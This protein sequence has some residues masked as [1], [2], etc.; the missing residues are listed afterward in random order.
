[1]CMSYRQFHHAFATVHA[2]QLKEACP[3]GPLSP[4]SKDEAKQVSSNI[5]WIKM[6]NVF[7]TS[8]LIHLAFLQDAG[9]YVFTEKK[10]DKIKRLM[11]YRSNEIIL[12]ST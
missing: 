2:K 10:S 12:D 3:L 4:S 1:M 9:Y 6:V 5:S 11:K 7:Q 8:L